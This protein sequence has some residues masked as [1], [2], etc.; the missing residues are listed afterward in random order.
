TL[1]ADTIRKAAAS[2]RVEAVAL[3]AEEDEGLFAAL[4]SCRR[5]LADAGGVPAY[6]IFV[7]RTLI[8]MATRRPATLDEM[9]GIT[10]V[11]AVKLELFGADFLKVISGEGPRTRP[12]RRRLAGSAEGPLMD[13]L[14]RAQLVLSRGPEG[15]GKYLACNTTTL[16]RIAET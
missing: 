2:R 3:V 15:R 8:E 6:M 4:K 9:R 10:G 5:A 16:A 1:R 12:A 14:H 11:G 13:R 7:D